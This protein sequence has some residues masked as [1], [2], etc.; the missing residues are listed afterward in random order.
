M[1]SSTKLPTA[2]TTLTRRMADGW[3]H[4][5]TGPRTGTLVLGGLSEDTDG[6]GRRSRVEREVSVTSFMLAGCHHATGRAF[7]AVWVQQKSSK[8]WKLDIAVRGRHDGEHTP[9]HLD[10]GQ[11]AA[12]AGSTSV[13]DYEAQCRQL[14]AKREETKRKAAATRAAR[15][16]TDIRGSVPTEVTAA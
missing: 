15:R 6:E 7:V 13:L 14:A 12:Y 8:S 9:Q 5:I 2:I 1:S 3:T 16:A 10:A 11:L 4:H